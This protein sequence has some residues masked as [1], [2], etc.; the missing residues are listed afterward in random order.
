LVKLLNKNFQ[1]DFETL[2]ADPGIFNAYTIEKMDTI[3]LLFQTG[4]LTI[5]NRTEKGLLKLG[6]PNKEVKDAMLKYLLGGYLRISPGSTAPT[7]LHILEALE[8]N[9]LDAAKNA[10]QALFKSI[11]A[12]IFIPKSEKYYH[13]IIHL[14]FTILGIYTQ[15]EVYTSDGRM[16]A[17]VITDKHIF[18]FEFKLDQTAQSA[19]TQIISKD[20]AARFRAA[21]KPITAIGINFSS[22]TKGITDWATI[23]L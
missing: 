16:D 6:Y 17:V 12:H 9:Q 7:V 21:G 23:E 13:S 8:N 4:Y 5:K 11:P 19:I 14:T 20:Y 3:P 18:I 2:E 22:T 1:Y 15:S 10:L